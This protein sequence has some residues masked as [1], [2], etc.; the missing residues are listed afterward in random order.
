MNDTL[1]GTKSTMPQ[2][3]CAAFKAKGAPPKYH[4]VT[5]FFVFQ[6]ASVFSVL[7]EGGLHQTPPDFL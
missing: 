1:G 3:M 5:T 4:G 7:D 2:W 6:A